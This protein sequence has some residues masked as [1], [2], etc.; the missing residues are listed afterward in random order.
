MSRGRLGEKTRE[1][2][3]EIPKIAKSRYRTSSWPYT[4]TLANSPNRGIRRSS[5]KMESSSLM[6][7]KENTKLRPNEYM[8]RKNQIIP[9]M[10][11]SDSSPLPSSLRCGT[12]I[13]SP[14]IFFAFFPIRLQMDISIQIFLFWR[15]IPEKDTRGACSQ[16]T[17]SSSRLPQQQRSHRC[18]LWVN[19]FQSA[20][21]Y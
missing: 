7:L 10:F 8:A 13:W 17:N 21:R 18:L 1:I 20:I 3:H 12:P 4:S 19:A 6:E 9:Q 5:M 16:Q 14:L 2:N 11:C 15:T